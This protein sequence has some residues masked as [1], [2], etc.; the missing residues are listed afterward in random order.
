MNFTITITDKDN[1][2]LAQKSGK[3]EIFLVY[4]GTY[5]QGDKITLKADKAGF[6]LAKLDDC[7]DTTFAWLNGEYT[8]EI[9]FNEKK[10][11]YNPKCFTG[12]RHYLSVRKADSSEIAVR[13]NLAFNPYDCHE[14]TALFPHTWANVETRGES[15]F[16][17]RNAI[18]GLLANT[19]HGEWP[20][21]SWGINKNPQAELHLEFGR[22]VKVDTVVLY[23]RADFPHDAWWTSA[24]ITFSDGSTIKCPLEKRGDAQVFTFEPKTITSLKV[25]QLIKAD[26]PSPFPA[27]TQIQVFGIEG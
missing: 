15:V 23:L 26:D 6:V 2:S 22:K 3:D 12:E 8:L 19:F 21:S 10:M 27:L 25:D 17:S 11:S 4:D 16:A 5:T 18:D 9:P 20:Y 7:M 24:T 14:N 1:K 13:K